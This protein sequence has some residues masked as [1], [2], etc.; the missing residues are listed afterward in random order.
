LDPF[1]SSSKRTNHRLLLLGL[2][3]SMA[4]FTAGTNSQQSRDD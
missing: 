3:F 2:P 4:G 1:L